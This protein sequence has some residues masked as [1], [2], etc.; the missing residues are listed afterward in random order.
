MI[1]LYFGLPGQGKTSILAA[2]ALAATKDKRY[3]YVY[4]NVPLRIPGVTFIQNDCIGTYSLE[5]ALILIDEGT[6]FADSRDFKSFG[7]DKVYYF[8]LHRHFNVNIEIFVQQWDALDRK[9]R[10]ITD[11]VYYV[12]KRGLLGFWFTKFYRIPY[13]IIIPDAKSESQKLGE[14]VQGY[15]KPPWYIR[16]FAKRIFRPKYYNFF[17][18]WDHKTLPKLPPIYQ[19]YEVPQLL[20]KKKKIEKKRGFLKIPAP[21][22][23]IRGAK[24][25][26]REV[27][28]EECV[29]D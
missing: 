26:M 16:L 13:G 17:D 22:G 29:V 28:H 2:H 19:A 15:C 8:M 6:I 5:D 4:S 1:S 25:T 27:T 23:L 10:C 9:I 7:S 21:R 20:D 14:I 12:Y 11:R 18:S 3:K 24:P